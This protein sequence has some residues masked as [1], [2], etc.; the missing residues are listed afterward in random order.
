MIVTGAALLFFWIAI[1]IN[2][3]KKEAFIYLFYSFMI[4]PILNPLI[5][6]NFINTYR[7]SFYDFWRWVAGVQ[8]LHGGWKVAPSLQATT[9]SEK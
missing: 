3:Y 5:S 7:R 9:N 8:M 2:D 1:R 4:F 6:L